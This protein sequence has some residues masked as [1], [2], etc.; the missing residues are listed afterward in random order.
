NHGDLNAMVGGECDDSGDCAGDY[1]C[2]SGRCTAE[3]L[4]ITKANSDD[5]A[6]ARLEACLGAGEDETVLRAVTPGV[7]P[8][9]YWSRPGYPNEVC[10]V[11]EPDDPEDEALR[12]ECPFPASINP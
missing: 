9:C 8:L 12:V 5:P 10:W 2:R 11:P 4:E 6:I 7:T 1:Q 3:P